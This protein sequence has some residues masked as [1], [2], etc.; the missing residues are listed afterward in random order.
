MNTISCLMLAAAVTGASPVQ[1]RWS[2]DYGAALAATRKSDR[3]LLVMLENPA[4]EKQAASM[5]RFA[6]AGFTAST[7]MRY[8]LCRVD[9]STDYG[10]DVAKVFHTTEFP[11]TVIIDPNGREILYRKSGHFSDTEWDSLLTRFQ[12]G[13]CFT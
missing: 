1:D 9:V 8:H 11:A 4:D 3:P 5:A 13:I 2:N 10:K 7:L 12:D 6:P